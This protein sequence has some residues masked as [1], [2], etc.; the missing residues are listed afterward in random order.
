MVGPKEM[1]RKSLIIAGSWIFFY[2]LLL[3]LGSHSN[4][5]ALVCF[6]GLLIMTCGVEFSIMHDAS[7]QTYSSNRT[8]NKIALNLS[9]GVLGGC[10][11]SWHHEHV[12]KHHGFTNIL[13]ADPDVYAAH[14]LRLH[15]SDKWHFWQKWQHYYAVPLYS[16]MW[17]H[18]V[19][20]D[21]TNA[22]LIVTSL[23]AK[24]TGN[25]GS[26]SF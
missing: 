25:F 12:V 4:L 24:D 23:R 1:Y 26:S 19:F 20:L 18:W 11:F 6:I 10:S 13:G 7:H 17:L 8:I 2:T 15:P 14:V 22:L 9:L 3:T 5:I 21:V 16:F